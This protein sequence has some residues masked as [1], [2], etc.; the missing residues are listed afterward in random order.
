[1]CEREGERV[2]AV[3]LEVEHRAL[4]LGRDAARARVAAGE[5]Q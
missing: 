1:M 4:A 2:L 5:R 3:V